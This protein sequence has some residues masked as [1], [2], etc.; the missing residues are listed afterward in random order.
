M[1]KVAQEGVVWVVT[2]PVRVPV[3]IVYALPAEPEFFTKEV[4]LAIKR[5][6]Q[7]VEQKW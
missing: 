2:G 3:V 7:S 5:P 6:V 4:F 1:V